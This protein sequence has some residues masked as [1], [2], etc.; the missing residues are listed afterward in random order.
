MPD[1]TQEAPATY[2]ME[3]S[4][5][6]TVMGE[7]VLTLELRDPVSGALR[8]LD[9]TLGKGGLTFNVGQ[10]LEVIASA[11]NIEPASARE[12]PMRDLLKH[13]MGILA[14]LGVDTRPTGGS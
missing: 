14:F 13:M 5:P 3:L 12:I 9:L 8:G 10:V 7:K 11:A 6:I 1:G 4:K 2:T